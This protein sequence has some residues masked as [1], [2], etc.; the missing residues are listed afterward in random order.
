MSQTILLDCRY[1]AH[2]QPQLQLLLDQPAV[3]GRTSH[4]RIC[5]LSAGRIDWKSQASLGLS[6]LIARGVSATMQSHVSLAAC[7][8]DGSQVLEDH[9]WGAEIPQGAEPR[10]QSSLEPASSSC[11]AWQRLAAD[12]HP[13]SAS[14]ISFQQLG[15]LA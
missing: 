7:Q 8:L 14:S 2:I 1:D 13:A 6:C 5:S 9:T 10:R 12:L 11:G 3:R 15:L 4:G